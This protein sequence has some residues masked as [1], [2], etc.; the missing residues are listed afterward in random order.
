MPESKIEFRRATAGDA[1]PLSA[2]AARLFPLGGRPG[3]ASADIQAHIATQLTPGRFRQLIADP[4]THTVLALS[5]SEIV[6]YGVLVSN[7]RHEQIHADAQAEVRKFYVD[8]AYHGQGLARDLMSELLQAAS[9]SELVWLSVFSE[10]PRAI[11][12][13]ERFGFHVIG[14]QDYWVGHDCQKDFVMRRDVEKGSR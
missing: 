3:A 11:R 5:G 13:Y 14:T 8:P 12:F 6:G 10:N 2:L 9:P 4:A 7:C 1:A